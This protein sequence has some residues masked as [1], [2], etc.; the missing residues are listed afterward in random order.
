MTHV[1]SN[2]H[3]DYPD[4]H[5]DPLSNALFGF[6]VFLMSDCIL[7][8]A[9]FSAYVVLQDS[10][11]GGPNIK[12]LINLP[13]A[14]LE[15]VIFLT[16]AFAVALALVHHEKKKVLGW[17][18]FAFLLGVLFLAMQCSE[19]NQLLAEGINWKESAFLSAYFTLGGVHALHLTAGL[20][21]MILFGVQTWRRG[22]TPV[23]HMRLECVKLYW[24]FLN[25][26][27]IVVFTY[28]YLLGAI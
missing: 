17:Y 20:L 6:W 3:V 19:W 26:I 24:L 10:T 5:H 27:W 28:V 22:L 7:F 21:L 2:A 23:M 11:A 12:E 13:F 1:T 16:S 18:F 4:S 9:I 25:L 14:F 8:A 15:T